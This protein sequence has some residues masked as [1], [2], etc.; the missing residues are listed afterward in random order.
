MH[1]LFENII[2]TQLYKCEHKTQVFKKD[3]KK[4]SLSPKT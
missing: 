3:L 2:P 1:E 4:T